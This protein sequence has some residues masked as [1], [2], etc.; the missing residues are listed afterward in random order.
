MRNKDKC[1][2]KYCFIEPVNSSLWI[3]IGE[4]VHV[5]IYINK[6][7]IWFINIQFVIM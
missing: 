6:I 5:T 7:L 3:R 4:R 1:I 2:D